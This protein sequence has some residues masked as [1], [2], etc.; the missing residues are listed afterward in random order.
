[1]IADFLP[2]IPIQ[3]LP[4]LIETLGRCDDDDDDD[5]GGG[6][7]DDDDDDDVGGSDD[8]HDVLRRLSVFSH[9]QIRCSEC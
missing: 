9:H 2:R 3:T 5:G 8:D 4:L 6:G 1:M 7:G